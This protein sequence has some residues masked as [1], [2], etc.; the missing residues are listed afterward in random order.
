MFGDLEAFLVILASHHLGSHLRPVNLPDYVDRT[1]HGLGG[2]ER[3]V[4]IRRPYWN[5]RLQFSS[6]RHLD[7]SGPH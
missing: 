5:Y 3:V 6:H 1:L 2:F 7:G 4:L